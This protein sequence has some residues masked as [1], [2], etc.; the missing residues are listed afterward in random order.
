MYEDITVE[1]IKQRIIARLT[2]ALDTR[3]GSHTNEEISAVAAEL[4][5]CYHVWDSLLPQFYLDEGSGRYIDKQAAV[6]G[7]TRKEGTAASCSITFTGSDSASVPAGTPFYTAAGLAF[8]LSES[9]TISSGTAVGLLVAAE[10][11]DIYN[12]GEGEIV[13]TLRN[14]SGIS[15]YANGA[16]A[17]GTDAESDEALLTRYLER[18]RRTATSGNPYHYQ[19]W[20]LEVAGVGAS[21]VISKWDGPGT[22][23]VV[24]AGPDMGPVAEP[25]TAACAAYIERQRPVG[26]EVTVTSARV[27]NISVTAAVAVDGST[28][29]ET[30]AAEFQAAVEVYLSGLAASAFAGNVD[31]QLE[32]MGD[33]AYTVLYNRIAYLLLSVSGVTDYE[34]LTVNGG[35][36]NI[37]VAAD[38]VPVLTGVSVS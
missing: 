5:E 3:E 13:K 12:I 36:A 24:L 37:T 11:G 2:T 23:K 34:A 30:V 31:L 38:E 15:G 10:T 8:Y 35:S 28:S 33:K 14:Y 17:G 9:I 32:E 4:A 25:I 16:A 21:R 1:G 19:Q 22:V 29:R 26:A 7:I 18:M 20:A 27:R 6:V